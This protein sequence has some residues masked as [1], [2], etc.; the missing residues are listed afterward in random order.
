MFLSELK[1]LL[2]SAKDEDRRQML[3]KAISALDDVVTSDSG[4]EETVQPKTSLRSI[5][6]PSMH[7]SISEKEYVSGYFD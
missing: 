4:L 3:S 6:H 1:R 5:I 7:S 2:S